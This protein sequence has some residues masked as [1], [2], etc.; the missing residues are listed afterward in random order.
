MRVAA[1]HS[2]CTDLCNPLWGALSSPRDEFT[3]I[4]EGVFVLTAGRGV[5]QDDNVV[6]AQGAVQHDRVQG[7]GGFADALLQFEGLG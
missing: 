2:I 6:L 4:G 1:P 3:Q 7:I 5:C